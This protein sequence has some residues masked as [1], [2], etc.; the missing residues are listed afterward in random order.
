MKKSILFVSLFAAVL[1]FASCCGKGK[2][3][4]EG[5]QC[6][7][8]AKA[9][10]CAKWAKF[11]SLTVEEQEALIA[12]RVECF[13]KSREACAAKKAECEKEAEEAKEISPECAAKKAE[14]EAAKAEIEAEWAAFETKTLAEKKA[15]FDKLDSLKPKCSK[16]D[17]EKKCCKKEADGEKK[18]CKKEAEKK[19]CKEKKAE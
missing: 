10:F 9:E 7:S 11:D 1:A 18:C 3:N 13:T 15:F 5:K 6:D 12:K 16:A 4:E 17:G 8:V 14:L 19:C 2:A